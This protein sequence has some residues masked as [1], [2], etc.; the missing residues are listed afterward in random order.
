MFGSAV[1][2]LFDYGGFVIDESYVVDIKTQ[3]VYNA[4]SL[5]LTPILLGEMYIQS[6]ISGG[7]R[8]IC[9]FE[10]SCDSLVMYPQP[11]TSLVDVV[12]VDTVC[13]DECEGLIYR[14]YYNKLIILSISL[15]Y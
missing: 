13:E 10:N 15:L 11:I 9:Y 3:F 7:G 1:D 2:L 14:G 4:P 8:Y 12:V 5:V 6:F